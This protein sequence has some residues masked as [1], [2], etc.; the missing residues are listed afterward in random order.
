MRIFAIRQIIAVF[1]GASF[2]FNNAEL[3]IVPY[4]LDTTCPLTYHENGPTRD[5]LNYISPNCVSGSV[6][7]LCILRNVYVYINR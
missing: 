7:L 1:A 6:Y 4:V 5:F 2:F 3:A